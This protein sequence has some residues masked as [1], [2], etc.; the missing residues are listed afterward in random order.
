MKNSVLALV[1]SLVLHGWV[2]A[3]AAAPA[4]QPS[5]DAA[6]LVRQLGADEFDI[7]ESASKKLIDMGDAA[8]PALEKAAA[9]PDADPEVQTR[10]QTIINQIKAPKQV[11]EARP[12]AFGRRPGIFLGPGGGAGQIIVRGAMGVARHVTVRNVNGQTEKTV[13]V[14][15][16]GRTVT[17]SETNDLV[18]VTVTEKAADGKETV[19]T[20]EAKTA[21]ELKKDSPEMF[22]HYEEAMQG[23]QVMNIQVNFDPAQVNPPDERNKMDAV[24]QQR[25]LTEREQRLQRR[26]EMM[27]ELELRRQ[28]AQP[29]PRKRTDDGAATE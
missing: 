19:K 26:D 27:K 17:V 11:A 13:T 7:R 20:A 3:E 1:V 28:Q 18:K 14:T 25:L 29:L 15:T 10:A 23:V 12:G 8:V 22:K 6:A 2:W 21:E 16:E 4:T 5:A 24:E 9:D